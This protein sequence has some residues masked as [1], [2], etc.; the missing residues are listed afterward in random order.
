MHR[1]QGSKKKIMSVLSNN[2]YRK[3]ASDYHGYRRFA[4]LTE[5]GDFIRSLSDL[6]RTS[7]RFTNQF[8]SGKKYFK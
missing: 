6:D 8:V 1:E 4:R 2:D 5:Q 3:E 7:N